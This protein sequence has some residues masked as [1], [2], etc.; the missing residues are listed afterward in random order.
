MRVLIVC[1]GN[2][3]NFKFEIHQAFVY[4][5]VNSLK[6]L[7]HSI[8]FFFFFIKR[9]GFWGYLSYYRE[10][11][12]FL[13]KNKIELIHAHFVFSGLLANLQRKVPVICSYHGTD[14]NNS[15][16]RIFSF[17]VSLLSKKIIVVSKDLKRRSFFKNKNTIIPCGV[18]TDIFK[19]IEGK[20]LAV[21]SN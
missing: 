12:S 15:K 6:R 3:P 17:F 16:N 10:L 1:S 2:Q 9:K 13:K 11:K 19:P 20:M 21:I 14:I 18:D 7:N 8:D 4:D 5:Q